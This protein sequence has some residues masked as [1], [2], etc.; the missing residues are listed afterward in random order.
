MYKRLKKRS[1]TQLPL[2]FF[3]SLAPDISSD[4]FVVTLRRLKESFSNS[5]CSN[6]G[7]SFIDYIQEEISSILISSIGYDLPDLLD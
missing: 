4:T 3:F 2:A 5:K 6:G 1:I 7:P